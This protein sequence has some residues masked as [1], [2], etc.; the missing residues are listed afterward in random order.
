MAFEGFPTAALDFYAGVAA[1]NDPVWFE[2]HR[3]AYDGAVVAPSQAF[4][5][6]LGQ[7]LQ[8]LRPEVGYSPNHTGRGSFKKIHTDRRFNPDRPPFKTYAQMI[9]WEG[10]LAQKKANSVFKVHFEPGKV[11]VGAGLWYF[12]GKLLKA[13]RA[14]VADDAT[15][16]PL[17]ALVDA[18]AAKG[19]A[20]GHSHYQRVPRGYAADHPRAGL[21]KHDGLFARFTAS[22]PPAA[23]HRA[24]F[25]DWALDHCEALA[26]LH[27]WCVDFLEGASR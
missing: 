12:D 17:Q 13:Y 22:P 25:V 8:A 3:E 21:L 1:H 14:A 9:F 23:F 6:A 16:A 10:P 27:G 7:R 2:A 26:P 24:D 11:V 18:L 15:G 5:E 4:I 19:Y 20:I